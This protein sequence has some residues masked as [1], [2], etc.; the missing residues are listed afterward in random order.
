M[1]IKIEADMPTL[2]EGQTLRAIAK[3]LTEWE[4]AELMKGYSPGECF[5]MENERGSIVITK[6]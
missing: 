4:V 6:M 1:K 3:A 2:A 5:K